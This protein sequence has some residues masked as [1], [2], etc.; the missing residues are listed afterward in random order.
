MEVTYETSEEHERLLDLVANWFHIDSNVPPR[1]KPWSPHVS[2]AYANP[3]VSISQ[4]YLASFVKRHPTL[5]KRR[6]IQ[7][8]SLWSTAGTMEAWKCLDR[9]PF[10]M[11]ENDGNEESRMTT[12]SL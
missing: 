4:E 6:R 2:L 1:A 12:F 8:I 10:E 9:I 7:A 5:R 3:E 11:T